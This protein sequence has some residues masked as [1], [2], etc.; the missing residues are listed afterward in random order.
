MVLLATSAAYALRSAPSPLVTSDSV[1]LT[2]DEAHFLALINYSRVNASLPPLEIAP[3]LVAAA[4]QHSDEMS[5]EGYFAHESPH[6]GS[7]T[8]MARVKRFLAEPPR[9]RWSVGECLYWS[10]APGVDRGHESLMGSPSHRQTIMD[11]EFTHIGVGVCIGPRSDYWVTEV[12]M[13][14]LDVPPTEEEF[15]PASNP[16]LT[17]GA[18]DDVRPARSGLVWLPFAFLTAAVAAPE[19]PAQAPIDLRYA[20]AVGTSLTYT[21]KVSGEGSIEAL[22]EKQPIKVSGTATL[23]QRTTAV[24][25]DGSITLETAAKPV[26]ITRSIGDTEEVTKSL[27][28]ITETITPRG[29]SLKVTGYEA[30]DPGLSALGSWGVQRLFG[31]ARPPAFPDRPV[32][33]GETWGGNET[34]ETAGGKVEVKR[35]SRLAAVKAIR[36]HNC[37]VIE[38]VIELPLDIVTPPD[39]IGITATIKGTETIRDTT[40][41]DFAQGLIV[42]QSG[43]VEFAFTTETKIPGASAANV[44]PATTRL[45]LKIDTQLKD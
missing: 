42:A 21:V 22:G 28:T 32:A 15:A 38:S 23:L 37:A 4:R 16:L 39:P 9:G 14:G 19:P 11:P 30:T 44:V 10:S 7:Q 41:F 43:T 25:E 33:I 18:E 2:A 13:C 29:R 24:G 45:I 8:P 20:L 26:S 6:P 34:V 3:A 31:Q 40:Y 1:V 27:P 5:R 35:E 12:F 17:I 36:G